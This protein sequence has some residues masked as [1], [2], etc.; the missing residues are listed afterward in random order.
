MKLRFDLRRGSTGSYERSV[1][2]CKLISTRGTVRALLLS[3]Y[4]PQKDDVS[5]VRWSV[6]LSFVVRPRPAIVTSHGNGSSAPGVG[7]DSRKER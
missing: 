7:I 5:P 3:V 4:L 2:I 6:K 1:V